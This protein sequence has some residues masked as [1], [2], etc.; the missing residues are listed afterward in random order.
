[1]SAD[2]QRER[3]REWE[4]ETADGTLRGH[5]DVSRFT[6]RASKGFAIHVHKQWQA[7]TAAGSRQQYQATGLCR[8]RGTGH[9]G[10]GVWGIIWWCGR[11]VSG[12]KQQAAMQMPKPS[13]NLQC[14]LTLFM[15]VRN[16]WVCVCVCMC[17][18]GGMWDEVWCSKWGRR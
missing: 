14:K 8:L 17:W 7:T 4:R 16:V 9:G 13:A 2:E 5:G 12:S 10:R 11:G 15:A 6:G 3:G 18:R 1:M